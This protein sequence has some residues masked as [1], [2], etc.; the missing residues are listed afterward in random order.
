MTRRRLLTN[1][2]S[3]AATAAVFVLVGCHAS[4][5]SHGRL[6]AAVDEACGGS[7][8][9]HHFALA[10]DVTVHRSGRADPPDLRGALLYDTRENRLVVRFATPYGG[11]ASCGFDGHTLWVDDPGNAGSGDWPTALQWLTW[12]A[13]PYRLTE[14]VLRVR[15]VEP[16]SIARARFRVAEIQLPAD[17][18][19]IC[20]LFVDPDTLQLRGGIP[21]RPA[22]LAPDTVS[23]AYA[24]AYEQ[25]A[26]CEDVTLPTRWS[27]WTWDA[28]AGIGT[29][30]PVA[31]VT[32][33]NPH[34]VEPDPARFA[35][36]SSGS[37][38]LFPPAASASRRMPKKE[39][40][41]AESF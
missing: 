6:P 22:G 41:R 10:A 21:V 15:E 20:A 9:R 38:R 33:D 5:V 17:G 26:F 14:P 19:V 30:G 27:V 23:T 31:S 11:E 16:V 37:A 24:F 40:C 8:W 32:L 4:P 25:F 7:A 34:F 3:I 29:R 18:P 35:P 13:V 39:I 12:V 28:R 2:V 36:P 1:L